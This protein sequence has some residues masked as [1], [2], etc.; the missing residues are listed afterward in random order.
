MHKCNTSRI[1]YIPKDPKDPRRMHMRTPLPKVQKPDFQTAHMKNN[2]T[3][4]SHTFTSGK[5]RRK[6]SFCVKVGWEGYSRYSNKEAC[7]GWAVCG[8]KDFLICDLE[9]LSFTL[10]MPRRCPASTVCSVVPAYGRRGKRIGQ[11]SLAEECSLN[12]GPL[13]PC[14]LLPNSTP[15][16]MLSFSIQFPAPTTGAVCPRLRLPN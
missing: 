13:L 5:S 1:I 2:H 15:S 3:L 16:I 14:F 4:R 9:P 7:V 11:I 12:P 10:S 6:I 8:R